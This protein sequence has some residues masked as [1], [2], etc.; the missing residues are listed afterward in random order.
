MVVV[1]LLWVEKFEDIHKERAYRQN[2]NKA[3]VENID[4]IRD[5]TDKLIVEVFD[6][7]CERYA[8]LE[9]EDRLKCLNELGFNVQQ[10]VRKPRVR[11]QEEMA[12]QKAEAQLQI[13]LF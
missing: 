5:T 7:A 10:V 11:K 6:A 3:E 12:M 9:F 2:L 4:Y 8:E 1:C 13:P